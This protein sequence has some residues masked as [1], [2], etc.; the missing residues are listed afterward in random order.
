M[1]MD[2]I[3]D[4]FSTVHPDS[5]P[6]RK[7]RDFGDGMDACR[8]RSGDAGRTAAR[9]LPDLIKA[10]AAVS[11]GNPDAVRDRGFD[12]RNLIKST[13]HVTVRI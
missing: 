7:C 8:C 11:A 1:D 2:P 4:H 12:K 3:A 10:G 5:T 13:A 9:R 6:R